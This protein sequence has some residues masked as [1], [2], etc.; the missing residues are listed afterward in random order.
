[1]YYLIAVCIKWVNFI[2]KTQGGKR[3]NRLEKKLEK[4]FFTYKMDKLSCQFFLMSC[5][6]TTNTQGSTS[7]VSCTNTCTLYMKNL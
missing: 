2:P 1:M 4:E 7:P 6:H 5:S 3:L